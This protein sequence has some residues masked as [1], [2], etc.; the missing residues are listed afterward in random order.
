MLAFESSILPGDAIATDAETLRP[1][2]TKKKE[3]MID[4]FP[5]CWLSR[6]VV[7]NQRGGK[8]TCQTLRMEGNIENISILSLKTHFLIQNTEI[9]GL[10]WWSS[11]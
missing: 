8:G 1:Q 4:Y 7:L 3:E 6:S 11:S 5:K 9:S 10:P 2:S